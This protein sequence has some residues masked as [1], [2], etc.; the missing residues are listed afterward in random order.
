MFNDIEIT[1]DDNT[2]VSVYEK[3]ADDLESNLNMSNNKP[4]STAKTMSSTN[5]GHLGYNPIPHTHL[6]RN[7]KSLIMWVNHFAVNF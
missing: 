5:M 1:A 4:M 2:P 6:E 7:H 3:N